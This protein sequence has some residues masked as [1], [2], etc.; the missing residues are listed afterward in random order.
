MS[1]E[2]TERQITITEKQL[3]EFNG[4]VEAL[5]IWANGMMYEGKVHFESR[6]L[7]GNIV[8]CGKTKW[9]KAIRFLKKKGLAKITGKGK[10]T[11][12]TQGAG[13]GYAF[14]GFKQ[15]ESK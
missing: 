1:E 3:F 2:T 5:M 11:T 12:S 15:G 7:T 14:Y 8:Y 4:Q 6:E 9:L 10:G 13:T